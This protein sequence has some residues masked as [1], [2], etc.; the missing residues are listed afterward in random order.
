MGKDFRQ[1]IKRIREKLHWS[2]EKLAYYCGV[3]PKTVQRWESKKPPKRPHTKI[4]N[5]LPELKRLIKEKDVYA[6]SRPRPDILPSESLGKIG[7]VLYARPLKE[8]LR[9]EETLGAGDVVLVMLG[10]IEDEKDIEGITDT[11]LRNLKKGVVYIYPFFNK[12]QEDQLRTFIKETYFTKVGRKIRGRIKLYNGPLMAASSLIVNRLIYFYKNGKYRVFLHLPCSVTCFL[13]LEEQKGEETL[14]ALGK[15]KLLK[16][17]EDARR[18][19]PKG[20]I[21]KSI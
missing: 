21:K 14:K 4:I 5:K 6:L 2:Q 9:L 1:E 20:K 16:F 7:T 17:I 15:E 8:Q 11:V 19:E 18:P 12:D 13:D 10:R 3:T